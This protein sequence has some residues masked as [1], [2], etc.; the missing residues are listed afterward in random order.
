MTNQDR[1][2]LT[3]QEQIHCQVQLLKSELK[4]DFVALALADANYRDI[5]WKIALGA[6]TE[7]Y[8]KIMVRMGKGMAGKVLKAKCPYIITYFP[9]EVQDEMLEYPIFLVESLRSGLGVS[10]DS[11]LPE[12]KHS[13]GVLLVGQREERIFSHQEIE[14]VEQYASMLAAL[15]DDSAKVLST[16]ETKET[17]PLDLTSPILHRLREF[18]KEGFTCELLDQ[19]IT[20]LSH[21]RQ[22]EISEVLK[23]LAYDCSRSQSN[24]TLILEQDQ[25][26]NTLVMFEGKG[27]Y[28][29]SEDVFHAMKQHL[30]SLKSD[31]EISVEED[32]QSVRFTLP[33]RLLLDEVHW[34]IDQT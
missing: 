25:I 23:L 14:Q 18:H 8:R 22:H 13:Y 29:L 10:V 2:S 7:R 15:Y 16:S 4:L 17:E 21:R 12:Q 20:R 28:Y 31:F 33:T 27:K 26:G 32:C 11:L 34:S 1:H 19:R 6:R 24:A 30:K 9:E 3:I 5:Y